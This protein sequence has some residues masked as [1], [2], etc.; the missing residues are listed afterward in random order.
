MT[1][2]EWLLNEL[3][4]TLEQLLS[5]CRRK[6]YSDKRWVIMWFY[7]AAGKSYPYIARKIGKDQ[8]SVRYACEKMPQAL[9]SHAEKLFMRYVTEVLGEKTDFEPT[10][11]PKV[12]VK[13]PDYKHSKVVFKDVEQDKVVK[14]VKQNWQDRRWDR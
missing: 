4:M 11:A 8:S 9:K 14:T 10:E 1:S 3:N 12:K 7:R 13:V 5:K 6:G 2:R